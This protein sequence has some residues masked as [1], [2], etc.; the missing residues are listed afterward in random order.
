MSFGIRGLNSSSVLSVRI[1]LVSVIDPNTHADLLKRLLS[2][3][4]VRARRVDTTKF[5]DVEK[6]I[7]ADR[8]GEEVVIGITEDLGETIAIAN[9]FVTLMGK[10]VLGDYF[11]AR[12]VEI[13][14]A[15]I[16][17]SFSFL[18]PFFLYYLNN[19]F[20]YTQVEIS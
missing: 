16:G 12:S 4:N 18:V 17:M 20:V 13:T 1:N 10:I 2:K 7:A 14:R 6:K 15:E 9:S 5:E 11:L 8:D 19:Y 3:P